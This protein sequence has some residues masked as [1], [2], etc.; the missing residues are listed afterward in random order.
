MRSGCSRS[1]RL[2]AAPAEARHLDHALAGHAGQEAGAV[3]R[4]EHGRE[5]PPPRA[6][7]VWIV[8]QRTDVGCRLVGIAAIVVIL[9]LGVEQLAKRAGAEQVARV[10]VLLAVP[11]RFGHHVLEPRLLL[12]FLEHVRVLERQARGHGRHNVPAAFETHPGVLGV[13]RAAGK[14][15]HG[16]DV[17]GF[18]EHD[19][20]RIVDRV[21]AEPLT[22][23]LAPLRGTGL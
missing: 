13:I 14:N 3:R 7:A 22:Q 19:L 23:S 8:N 1:L 11:A 2:I 6:T 16:V 20:E 15:R 5:T 4:I 9:R 21:A 18:L 12:D 10:D 17:L